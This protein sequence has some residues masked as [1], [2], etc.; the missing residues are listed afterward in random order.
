MNHKCLSRSFYSSYK[1]ENSDTNQIYYPCGIYLELW[2][3]RVCFLLLICY[4]NSFLLFVTLHTCLSPW[5]KPLGRVIFFSV[6]NW[7]NCSVLKI[8]FD[9]LNPLQHPGQWSSF[10]STF[11]FFLN[12]C[13]WTI[14]K[15]SLWSFSLFFRAW[16]FHFSEKFSFYNHLDFSF[17]SS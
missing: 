17:F 15:L 3:K 13:I 10:W 14:F 11:H 1:L 9:L 16:I 8:K 6:F 2:E 4:M 7:V 5:I 12:I